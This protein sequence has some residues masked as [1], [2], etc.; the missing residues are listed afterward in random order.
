MWLEKRY[1]RLF[2][3]T[4][5][6]SQQLRKIREQIFKAIGDQQTGHETTS[7]TYTLDFGIMFVLAPLV[8]TFK[9]NYH[10]LA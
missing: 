8:K 3:R 2:F 4:V 6:I 1:A 5:T 9:L 10:D 7:F